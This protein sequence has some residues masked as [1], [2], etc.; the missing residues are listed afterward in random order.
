MNTREA[1]RDADLRTPLFFDAENHPEM[2][3]V[4]KSARAAGEGDIEVTGDLTIRGTTHEVTL[5]VRD[6]SA[7]QVDM[8]GTHAHRRDRFDQDQALRLR[9]DLEQGARDGRR[10]R[11]RGRHDYARSVAREGDLRALR[12][13]RA[14]RPEGAR[15]SSRAVNDC[16]RR[17]RAV[18]APRGVRCVRTRSLFDLGRSRLESRR[19][20]LER[21]HILIS[22]GEHDEPDGEERSFEDGCHAP[23]I[24]VVSAGSY[25]VPLAV[26]R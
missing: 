2:T 5:A 24:V 13:A 21:S 15:P 14:P 8:R 4:S 26:P 6:V 12:S 19:E 18:R 22:E 11:R 25:F 9:D 20:R 3:F 23:S 10:G 16:A 1:K 17:R 7:P